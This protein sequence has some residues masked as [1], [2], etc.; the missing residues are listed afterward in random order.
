MQWVQGIL[1][2]ACDRGIDSDAILKEAEL[3]V[4]LLDASADQRISLD[5]TVRLWRAV[6][7]LTDDPCFGLHMGEQ[8]RPG[9][10]HVVSY[11]LMSSA[12]LAE[13]LAKV[14]KYQSLISE[15]GEVELKDSPEG[16]WIVYNPKA[17]TL[18]FSRHQ[19]EAVLVAILLISRW[20]VARELVP[21]KVAFK[22]PRPDDIREHQRLFACDLVF[23]ADW[24]GLLVP[25]ALFDE[26]L[27]QADPGMSELHERIA[28]ERLGQLKARSLSEVVANLIT[29]HLP[30]LPSREEVA[31]QLNM[32]VRSMQ[33]KLKEDGSN[34]QQITDDVRHKAALV[35]LQ[36]LD[37]SL[38]RVAE[39]LGFS[40][41]STFYRA[42]K[43]WQ[44]LTPGDYRKQL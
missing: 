33:R 2:A 6:E 9:H 11:T 43:R 10:L 36:D 28:D 25:K 14:I 27:P 30:E 7:Q 31:N 24:N 39:Q 29:S 1:K 34:F 17:S 15:G 41:L 23:E 12:T 35:M 20:L 37:L 16:C 19:I 42:F 22:H 18:S 44:G 8:L 38:L 3:P 32:S 13:V 26:P 21:L 4:A 40:E 5:D